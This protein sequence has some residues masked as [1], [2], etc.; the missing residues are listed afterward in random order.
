MP[1]RLIVASGPLF[2]YHTASRLTGRIKDSIR[3]EQVD[4]ATSL[5]LRLAAAQDA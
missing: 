1:D 3:T 5:S 2:I 4:L